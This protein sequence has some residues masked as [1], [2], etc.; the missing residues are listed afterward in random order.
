MFRSSNHF[1]NKDLRNTLSNSPYTSVESCIL[2][3]LDSAIM[4]A[5]CW[6]S[7]R[8]ARHNT[9]SANEIPKGEDNMESR[10]G[11][12]VLSEPLC[13]K[14]ADYQGASN[15][16]IIDLSQLLGYLVNWMSSVKMSNGFDDSC[17]IACGGGVS[18]GSKSIGCVLPVYSNVVSCSHSFEPYPTVPI[19]IVVSDAATLR[20][21]ST[22]AHSE[23]CGAVET[24]QDKFNAVAEG[25]IAATNGS[26]IS[27][28]VSIRK[29]SSKQYE[30]GSSKQDKSNDDKAL[31]AV[32]SFPALHL[33][34]SSNSSGSTHITKVPAASSYGCNHNSQIL[35]LVKNFLQLNG[36]LPKSLLVS[37]VLC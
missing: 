28:Q 37:S 23:Q 18:A 6:C 17:V 30:Q 13:R 7:C 34:V 16:V 2:S 8:N 3:L 22:K 25:N 21:A 5:S 19:P 9:A 4:F 11:A 33:S 20:G 14:M 24:L 35:D 10:L 26:S 29:N 15:R 1:N 12:E 36:A 32:L 31:N 27:R